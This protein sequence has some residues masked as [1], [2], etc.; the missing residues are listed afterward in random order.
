MSKLINYANRGMGLENDINISNEYY[1]LENKAVIYKRP[2]PIQVTKV[3]YPQNKITEAYFKTPSTTDYNGIYKGKYLDFEAKEIKSKTSF[4][5]SNIHIHQINHLRNIIN[6]GGIGFI[7]VR[8]T[9]LGKTFLLPGNTLIDF[10][11]NEVKKSIP[12]SYFEENG[13]LLKEK[14]RPRIDYLEVVDILLEGK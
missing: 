6:H 8:F 13:Y 2:T 7:I 14:L 1:L 10:I 4:A 9:T 12:L 11:S 5:L 3:V